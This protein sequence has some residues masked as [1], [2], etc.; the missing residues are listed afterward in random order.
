MHVTDTNI[1][2]RSV[3]Y[4]RESRDHLVESI[5]GCAWIDAGKVVV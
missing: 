1:H 5:L 3:I 2:R 4:P